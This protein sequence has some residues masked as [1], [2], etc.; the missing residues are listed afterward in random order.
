MDSPGCL[1]VENQSIEIYK[2]MFVFRA[3]CVLGDVPIKFL[4]SLELFDEVDKPNSNWELS[5][6]GRFQV[7]LR[8]KE[9]PRYWD[10]LLKEGVTKPL[11][12]QIWWEMRQKFEE[13]VQT[14]VDE[15]EEKETAKQE[16]EYKKKKNKK[17]KKKQKKDEF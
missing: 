8:K 5:S 12:M 16:Q 9:S 13:E 10:T 3:Y 1:E 15:L 11:N 14:Y 7:T 6:V 4:L 2:D 17:G